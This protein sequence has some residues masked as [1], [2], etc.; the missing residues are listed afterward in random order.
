MPG[1]RP[2]T[3]AE[4][5]GV[6]VVYLLEITWAGRKHRFSTQEIT[7]TS[8][9]GIVRYSG[10]LNDQ[11]YSV[12]LDRL[13]VSTEGLSVPLEVV[14]PEG[15]NVAAERRASRPLATA[16]G[17]LSMVLVRDGVPLQTYDQRFW[18]TGGALVGCQWGLPSRPVGW[19]TFTLKE[20]AWDDR[21]PMLAPTWQIDR[22]SW[23]SAPV[24]SFGKPY[25]LVIGEPGL[26]IESDGGPAHVHPTPAYCIERGGITSTWI[27]SVGPV[28]ASQVSC[29]DDAGN[30]AAVAIV[31]MTDGRGT[32]VATVT[33]TSGATSLV[34][35]TTELHCSWEYGGGYLNPNDLGYALEKGGDLI[36]WILTRR[37]SLPVDGGAWWAHNGFLNRVTFDGFVNDPTVE[38]WALLRDELLRLYPLSVYRGPAGLAPVLHYPLTPTAQLVEVSTGPGFCLVSPEEDSR[39]IDA[40]IND[41][42]LEYAYDSAADRWLDGRRMSGW[43]ARQDGD[44]ADQYAQRSVNTYGH[45]PGPALQSGWIWRSASAVAI[46][47][48]N[49]REYG[50]IPSTITVH[51]APEYGWL[52]IGR[53]VRLVSPE[54][55]L[56]GR[57]AQVVGRGWRGD[58]RAWELTLHIDAEGQS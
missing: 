47:T 50:F 22:G 56:T 15:L 5:A 40:V 33:I 35:T 20:Q 41:V 53:E 49:L 52:R 54:L 12:Q 28:A 13:T 25:T 51:A 26:Y 37:M 30:I 7:L 9:A 11:D 45:R 27:V 21:A 57:R 8:A 24:E 48:W 29:R 23:V 32:I 44:I 10:G 4:L 38:A 6:D 18:L 55:E 43:E 14:F 19:A 16:R 1:F 58:R 42:K 3:A 46:L 31:E 34:P 36:Q 39:D 17:E 2:F